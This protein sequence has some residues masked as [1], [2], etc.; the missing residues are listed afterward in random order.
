[1]T[2]RR[3]RPRTRRRT[4][5]GARAAASGPA[6][7]DSTTGSP[8]RA[9]PLSSSPRTD[10]G[11]DRPDASSAAATALALRSRRRRPRAVAARRRRTG[12]RRDAL[13]T[14]VLFALLLGRALGIAAAVERLASPLELGVL[15]GHRR[16]RRGQ[17]ALPGRPASSGP[18]VEQDRGERTEPEEEE[19]GHERFADQR[20]GEQDPDADP[21]RAHE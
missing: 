12:R 16:P 21:E 6:A 17:P 13:C 14:G 19:Q 2:G 7:D 11:R 8:S 15:L 9:A 5:S 1:M 20:N 3:T 4:R 10:G 18:A